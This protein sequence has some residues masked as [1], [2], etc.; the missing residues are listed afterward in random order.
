MRNVIYSSEDSEVNYRKKDESEEE[1]YSSAYY[2]LLG[3]LMLAGILA[4]V[5]LNENMGIGAFATLLVLSL[6]VII[7]HW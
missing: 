1:L 5:G 4:T 3:G 6:C 7:C 2:Y